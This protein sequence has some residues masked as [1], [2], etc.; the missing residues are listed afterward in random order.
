MPLPQL[1]SLVLVSACCWGFY[2][3]VKLLVGVGSAGSGRDARDW[4]TRVVGTV[5]WSV[6]CRHIGSPTVNEFRESYK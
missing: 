1:S 2:S 5:T 4:K 6:T 3:S